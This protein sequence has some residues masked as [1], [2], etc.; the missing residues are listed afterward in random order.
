[1]DG[2]CARA[3]AAVSGMDGSRERS[4]AARASASG[5]SRLGVS[6][7]GASVLGD[8]AGVSGPGASVCRSSTE[9]SGLSLSSRM[10]FG[11]WVSPDWTAFSN[12]WRAWSGR[13]ANASMFRREIFLCRAGGSCSTSFRR[14]SRRF[15]YGMGIVAILLSQKNDT[16]V[17]GG[18]S[19]QCPLPFVGLL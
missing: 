1:M 16:T 18:V 12:V 15:A 10:A 14:C 8:S 19:R 2:D 7:P 5:V 11:I 4:R 9:R 13:A 3:R 6:G 17:C